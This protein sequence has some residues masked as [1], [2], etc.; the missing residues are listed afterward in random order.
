M[1]QIKIEDL[2][3]YRFIENLSFDPSGRNYAYQLASIDKK[4]DDYFRTVY[5]NKKAFPADRSTSILSWYDEKHLIVTEESKDKKAV[6]QKY[7][8]LDIET[9]KRKNFFSFPLG[10]SS[11]KVVDRDTLV[12]TA[13]ID[14]NDPDLYLLDKEKLQKKKE[15]R[16]KEADYEVLDEIPYWFNG[17]GFRNKKRNALFVCQLRPFR[18]RRITEPLFDV[19]SFEVKDRKIYFFG[20]SYDRRLPLYQKIYVHDIDR[21]KTDCIYGKETHMLSGIVFFDD[22][23][24]VRASDC[25]KYGLNQT[26]EFHLLKDGELVPLKPFDRTLDESAAVDITLGGGK[27]NVRKDGFYYT[28]ATEKDHIELWQIDHKLN[29]KKLVSMPLISFF[30]VGTDRIVFCGCDDRS[31]PE[32]YEYTFKDRNVK[33]ISSFNVNAL[34]D[35]YVAVPREIG[36]ESLGMEL[37]G[38]VLLPKDFDKKKKYPAV[39]DVHGG[40]RAVYTRAFFHEMQVWA[41]QGYFVLYTNIRGS[42]GRGDE[43]ADIRGKYGQDDYRNLMDFVDTVLIRYPQI[44]KSRLCET[45][46]SYGGFMT[47]WIIGH[48]DRFCCAASQRSIANWTGF[49]Y[50]S[51]IGVYFSADQCG[52]DDPILDAKKLWDH[53]PLKYADSVRT[54]TLFIHSDQDYRCPMAEGMQMMQ[55]LADRNVQTRLVLFHGENHELSRSGKPSHRLR[56]LKEITDWFNA[57]AN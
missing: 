8:L 57:H 48:T 31:L 52:T 47:N 24:H 20:S 14:A 34:K 7:L 3:K 49:T 39:L 37:N 22:Q 53:S 40:P 56:R 1:K 32:L 45:G 18:I 41:S 11:L 19:S 33:R 54:P 17:M 16:K 10:I 15:E 50:L 4:K 44:D 51:D 30:D 29:K 2:L 46:G 5:V 23:I 9:G 43:F 38:W 27:C 21:S 28:L 13:F 25:R 55:A 36:Y 35:R 42:D 26:A 6:L 12:F